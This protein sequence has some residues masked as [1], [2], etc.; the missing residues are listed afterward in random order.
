M[1]FIPSLA[2]GV[3]LVAAIGVRVWL[4]KEFLKLTPA[5]QQRVFARRGCAYY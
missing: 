1:D 2:I 3:L 4:T 5:E